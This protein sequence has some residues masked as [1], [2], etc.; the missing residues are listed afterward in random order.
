MDL[1]EQETEDSPCEAQAEDEEDENDE[2]GGIK[3]GQGG[4]L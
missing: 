4:V 3:V 1:E 2:V